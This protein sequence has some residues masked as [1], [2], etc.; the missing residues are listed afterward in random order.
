MCA[1]N[2]IHTPPATV[3]WLYRTETEHKVPRR[4]VQGIA[5][6]DGGSGTGGRAKMPGGP[7]AAFTQFAGSFDP[8]TSPAL[9]D[10]Q[11][12]GV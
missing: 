9:N 12:T 8:L 10:G 7:K 5:R 4:G 3:V 1:A 6:S 11:L 2:G